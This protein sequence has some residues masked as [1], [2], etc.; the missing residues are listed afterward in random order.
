MALDLKKFGVRTVSAIVFGTLLLGSLT[1]YYLFTVFFLIVMLI[2]VWEFCRL[3][4][5]SAAGAFKYTALGAAF[6]LHCSFLDPGYFPFVIYLKTITILS[7]IPVLFF[8]ESLFTARANPLH[9]VFYSLGA[10][11]YSCLPF[12]MLHEIV[13]IPGIFSDKRLFYPHLLLSIILLIW[14]N[15]T[16]AYIWGSMLGKHKLLERVSPG[17]TTEGTVLGIL[18]AFGFSFLIKSL[19]F[20]SAF[21]LFYLAGFLVPVLAVAGDLFESLLKRS[22]GVKDSGRIMPGHGGMLDR[23]DS[24]IFVIPFIYAAIKWKM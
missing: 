12:G 3:A 16:F 1:N 5:S 18:T 8:F 24:L 11:I 21:P 14:I 17:K 19:L 13:F 10:I 6:L 9:T 22:A 15:D 7:L 20:D 2:A 23:F 4:E